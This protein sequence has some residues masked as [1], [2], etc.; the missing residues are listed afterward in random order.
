LNTADKL[1]SLIRLYATK[2]P[3]WTVEEAANELG[4]SVSTSYRYFRSLCKIGMLEPLTG[5]SYGLGPAIV[6]FDRQIR[7]TDPMIRLGKPVMQR[8]ISHS[9]GIGIAQLCRIHRN[10]VMC[11]HLEGEDGVK[12]PLSFERG[13]VMPMFR[14]SASKVVFANLPW[15]SIR[16]FFIESPRE[17]AEAGLGNAWLTVKDKIRKIRKARVVVAHGEVDPGKVG[18]SAPVFGMKKRVLGSIGLVITEDEATPEMV[19]NVSALVDAAGR[20]ITEGL[21][22]LSSA[23]SVASFNGDLDSST[24]KIAPASTRSAELDL[25]NEVLGMPVSGNGGLGQGDGV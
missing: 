9:G 7:I 17:I 10:G 25:T 11:I 5:S 14:G 12:S 13:R 6:E 24:K 22:N 18:I 8:L 2:K 3:E 20:Q 4:I 23:A 21:E 16:S 15:G 1:L 19:Y